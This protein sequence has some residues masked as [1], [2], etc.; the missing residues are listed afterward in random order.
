MSN[1]DKLLNAI[2]EHGGNDVVIS[3]QDIALMFPS[4]DPHPDSFEYKIIDH[5]L[6][7]EWASNN[8]FEV[9][10]VPERAPEN[11][12]HSPPVRFIKII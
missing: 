4:A 3:Y 6:L 9:S 2:M 7:R 8:G 10:T 1:E 5:Q 11:A 12:K